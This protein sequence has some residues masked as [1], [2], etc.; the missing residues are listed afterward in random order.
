MKIPAIIK[1]A[2]RIRLPLRHLRK[3]TH[4]FRI[5]SFIERDAPKGQCIR[6]ELGENKTCNRRVLYP[7]LRSPS[8]HIRIFRG[9]PGRATGPSAGRAETD[10]DVR[11]LW[12]GVCERGGSIHISRSVYP[13]PP[14]VTRWKKQG[15]DD[16]ISAAR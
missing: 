5:H 8:T 14:T 3:R 12:S 1:R 6:N 2:R 10:G 4:P 11:V 15:A 13:L 16:R 9:S 7:V